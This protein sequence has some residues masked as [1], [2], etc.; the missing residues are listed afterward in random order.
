MLT[1][2]STLA[3]FLILGISSLAL[4]WAKKLKLPHTVLLVLIGMG[5]GLLSHIELFSFFALFPEK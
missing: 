5:I 1:I 4:F 3:T 2:G